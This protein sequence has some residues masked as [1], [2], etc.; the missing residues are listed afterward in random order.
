MDKY[1]H[2]WNQV[3]SSRQ[4]AIAV[5]DD[6]LEQFESLFTKDNGSIIRVLDMG[7][8]AGNNTHFFLDKGCNVVSCDYSEAALEIIHKRI[9]Q[10]NTL[11]LDISQKLP[12]EDESF[13]VVVAD[14]SLHYFNEATTAQ[15]MNEVKRVLKCRGH[16]LARVNSIADSNYGA[17]Q[18]E[19]LEP[20]F[21]FYD[22]YEK[23]FFDTLDVNHYFGIVGNVTAKQAQMTRYPKPKEVFEIAVEKTL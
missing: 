11:R 12:F 18:G 21:Y 16:L 9:P 10:A 4:E 5:S 23:R 15:I 13:D 8:G 20:H 6:W 22:G 3:F 1:K 7:C 2:Y 17:C 19:Q 14:L